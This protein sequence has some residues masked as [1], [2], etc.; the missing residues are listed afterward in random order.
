MSTGTP[1]APRD[2]ANG[3]WQLQ[4][5]VVLGFAWRYGLAPVAVAVALLV[6]LVITRWIGPGLVTYITFYPAVVVVALLAGLGPG[7]F[8]TVLTG[9]VVAYWV[10]PPVGNLAVAAA[11]DRLGLAIFVAMGLFVSAV[12]KLY[13]RDRDKAAAWDRELA[14]RETRRE[15]EFLANLLEHAAQPF[16]VGY[17]DG[18]IGLVNHAFEEL[19]GYTAPEL[20]EIDWSAMLTP[21]EWREAEAQKL[22]ELVRTGKPVRYEKEYIRK[23]G[24]R[25]PIELLVHLIHDAQGQPE[26]Y[27][28][29]IA[30]ITERKRADE[31]LR[32]SEASLADAQRIAG[33]GSWEWDLAS[34]RL[35]WS[36]EMYRLLGEEPGSFVPTYGGFLALVHPEDRH[37]TEQVAREALAG[38]TGFAVEYRIVTRAGATRVVLAQAGVT[39]SPTGEPCRVVGTALEITERKRA[40]EDLRAA[41]Q[42]LDAHMDNSPMAVIEWGADM[43][44]TRWS[45]E[46]ERIFGWEASEVLG[47]RIGDFRWVYE[48]DVERVSE[49]SEELQQGVQRFSANRNYSKDGSVVDCHWYNSTLLDERGE[50]R[51]ILSLV[52][53]VTEQ[54]RTQAALRQSEERYRTL[55]ATLIEG[56]CI[57]EVLFDAEERPVDYRFLEVN[58]AFER[59]TGLKNAVGKTMR[60]LAPN[61]EAHWFEAYGKVALTGEPAR[62]VNEA[63]ELGRWYDVSAYRVGGPDSR[64]VAILFNDI[65][66]RKR[67]EEALR[68]AHE[69]LV[70]AQQSAGAAIWDWDIPAGTLEWSP[71]LYRLFGLDPAG[72][73]ASFD[74]WRS[75]IHADDLASAQERIERAIESNTQL[76][77]DYRIVR[78]GGEVRWVTALGNTVYDGEG[79]PLRM[80]GICI[81]VTEQ[82]RADEELRKSEERLRLVLRASSMGTF[83]VDLVT[84][85]GR[86]NETEYRLLGLEPGDVPPGP[87]PFFRY[88]HPDDVASLQARW[89]EALRLGTLD[90]EF[91]IVRP[92][93]EIRWLAGRG[94]FRFEPDQD[95]EAR[96]P[97]DFLGVNFDITARK[98][99]EEA[100]RLSEERFRVAQELSLDAF[101]IMTAV[102]DEEGAIEDFRWEFANLEAGRILRHPPEELVGRRLLELLPGNRDES[103]LFD[104]YVRVV[105]TGQPHD[106]ELRYRSEGIDGWFR[107]M[108]VKLGDG[109]AT[110]FADITER[111]RA[112]ETLRE[113]ERR[114]RER[115]AELAVLLEAVPASVF[116]AHDPDGVHITGNPA[117][118]ELLRSP[119]GAEAS[120]AAPPGVKPDHFRAMKD[121]RELRLDELPAQRAARG[122]HV[123]DFEFSLVFDDGASRSV[124][125][126]GT[127]LLDDGGKP[128][129]SVLVLVDITERKRAEGELQRQREWLRVT[130]TSIGDAVL[131]CDNAGVITFFNPVAAEL[132]GWTSEEALGQGVQRVFCVVNEATR[133]AGQDLVTLVL[134]EKRILALANHSALVRKDGTEIPIEDS[135]APILAAD[136]SVSGVVLVFHDVTEKRHAQA[137]LAQAH[138]ERERYLGQLEAA[139]KEKVV[140]LQEIHHRVKN[141]LQIIASLLSL[142]VQ[143]V[144]DASD[145]AALLESQNRVRT[146]ALIHETLYGSSDFA[147]I[148]FRAYV[149]DLVSL[150]QSSFR[151]GLGVVEIELDVEDVTFEI[152]TAI[153]LAL[154]LNEL[155]SNVYKHAFPDGRDGHVVIGLHEVTPG[156]FVFTVSDDGVGI[157]DGLEVE[158]AESM[159]M[160]VV[161]VLTRQ[162][163]GALEISREGGTRFTLT[164]SKAPARG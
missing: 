119:R 10:L 157:P 88:V 133:E 129:G 77:S 66:D 46:A 69:R 112:E 124:V 15:K 99:A 4:R 155:L 137:A 18:H 125:G 115:A 17:P 117:A 53:D 31:A 93:G 142:Q 90:A 70:L 19:T 75:V 149:A 128:R 136:G 62:F 101:T 74:L 5:S 116:I 30:D 84:G 41:R 146:L 65:G 150:V 34:G 85:V 163:E 152:T 20:A 27:Y 78:P 95:G 80:S 40:E 38:K 148:P 105:E 134:E 36:D 12:A 48:D 50:F 97:K 158:T 92:D 71:P 91:R 110:H 33:L 1:P 9:L 102:R 35:L 140:L 26:C 161:W 45:Q 47:K 82:K 23:D 51:S 143:S 111:K 141:N 76:Q 2:R 64:K 135:A 106:C 24:S 6:R 60:E 22:A 94:Q 113:S 58:P 39:L 139:L 103:D 14:L 16:A 153:P 109:V 162:I 107:N 121:G 83:E 131:A 7:V 79:K 132:T 98:V 114:E 59:Q 61:H 56:F 159:G 29:F 86:W 89:N 118:D 72:A 127:P 54:N 8:A 104:R 44:L 68:L 151:A 145:R 32:R 42:L 13:R 87:E 160:Q 122:E 37:R 67:A 81:D 164:F 21:P 43:R 130:L 138:A 108:T 28:S 63:R 100:L 3:R 96:S 57:I 49:V 25:V 147:N 123:R 154:I 156:R 144:K 120:L 126:Y 11:V 73:G 55:F 52:L